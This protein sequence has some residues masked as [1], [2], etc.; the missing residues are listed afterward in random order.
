MRKGADEIMIFSFLVML[1]VVLSGTGYYIYT[2]R[3][4][5][6]IERKQNYWL[7]LVIVVT[8]LSGFACLAIANH[9]SVDSFNLI[10]DMSPFWHLQL[11]RYVNCGSI[12]LASQLGLHQVLQ[13]RIF[14][15]IWM[16]AVSFTVFVISTTLYSCFGKK[17]IKV[18]L[19]ITFAV[20]LA[21]VNVFMME[22]VLFPEMMMV[23]AIGV[24]ALGLGIYFALCDGTRL[25]RWFLS[26]LFLI[27]ALGNYQ[28][29]IGI[30]ISFILIGLFLKWDRDE[31]S[32]LINTFFALACGGGSSIGN[33]F[34]VK[35]LIKIGVIADSGRG[36]GF[37]FGTIKRNVIELIKYQKRFWYNADGLLPNVIMPLIG[38]ALLFCLI[39]V[40][41]HMEWHRRIYLTGVLMIS[42]VL[43]F[44][45][46][47]IETN[48]VLSPRSNVAFWSTI[49]T[50][51]I[52]II[53][54]ETVE[55]ETKIIKLAVICLGSVGLCNVFYMQDMAANTRAVNAADFIEATQ[56]CDKIQNY[57]K[58]T[59]QTIRK[60]ATK[61]DLNVTL[62]P[63]FSRYWNWEFG[64]RIMV[65][66]YSNYQ[67]IGYQLG[68]SL[69]KIDM[70]ENVY[71]KYF[72][73]K[74]WNCLKLDEQMICEGDSIYLMIY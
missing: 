67:L 19:Y 10:F 54:S 63:S 66:P 26:M 5:Q 42:Y 60:V 23:S 70:P 7:L 40:L 65:T 32:F 3:G 62:T 36:A 74:D 6:V 14:C 51:F 29:Y 61:N 50:T 12:L 49:A 21:F 22:F 2:L 55:E 13:Q 41:Y 56:I 11:G 69:E 73:D 24:I 16:G 20:L 58:T 45:A 15:W 47:I 53:C 57:E 1:L 31:K 18:R 52:I 43:S 71:E 48:L 64:T 68:R 46:H 9:Y 59:G 33:I 28:S 39:R 37:E 17:S 8:I 4:L 38:I 27:I 34:L 72:K 44:A 25:K 35:L 30:Y